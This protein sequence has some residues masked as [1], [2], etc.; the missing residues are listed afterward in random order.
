[1]KCHPSQQNRRTRRSGFTLVELLVVIVIIGIL[2][3]LI[4][5]ALAGARNRA[6]IGQVSAEISQLDNAIAKFKSVYNV[7]PPSSLYIPA[8]GGTWEASDRSKV[9]GIWPQFDFASNGG[10]GTGNF[11]LSG[12]ECLVFF[13]GGIRTTTTPPAMLGFSKNP[14][15]PW[16]S[17]G[18]NR[19]G[20][21]FEF[22]NSRF[23]DK[24][25]DTVLEY[26]DA[27][28]AQTAPYVYFSSQGRSYFKANS[29]GTSLSEQDDFDVLGGNSN[30][31][32]FSAIYLKTL[33]PAVPQ[34]PNGYQIISPGFD[35]LYGVG[36]VYTD[37]SEL[38]LT[39]AAEADNITN[40]SGGPLKP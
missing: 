5:P 23:L 37:G 8:V 22:N 24:D 7:E 29:G 9:R 18:T 3:S 4:L 34:R 1:M 19:E 14:R 6:R 36:G 35:G 31:A 21:F 16:S 2:M 39:R 38:T 15:F 28:P 26:A 11:H 40:F 10:L 20:P 30:S 27:L 33:T 17:S 13:L 32:D 12:A 25:G